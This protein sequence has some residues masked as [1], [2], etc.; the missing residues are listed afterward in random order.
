[1]KLQIK[2]LCTALVAVAL[3]VGAV[4]FSWDHQLQASDEEGTVTAAQ[5]QEQVEQ[6]TAP[7]EVVV[8]EETP[9]EAP[10]PVD[11]FQNARINIELTNDGE[12]YYGD[13]AMLWANV[14]GV[15]GN[16]SYSIQWQT[17]NGDGWE[18]IPGATGPSYNFSI[19]P[20]N[21][22]RP[23]RAVMVCHN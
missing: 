20:A 5:Q 19:T 6:T 9:A 13:I 12:L 2:R 16:G 21:A 15:E 17:D 1:M 23:Y 7:V 8:P 22:T 11:P 18:N 4:Y 14:S 3:I 10:A